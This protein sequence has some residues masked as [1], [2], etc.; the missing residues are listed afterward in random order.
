MYYDT[1]LHAINHRRASS[2]TG[3]T[4]IKSKDVE[5]FVSYQELYDLSLCALGYL[6][7]R[8]LKPKDELVMQIED[9]RSFFVVFWA[10]LLGGIIPV[11]VTIGNNDDHREK[12]FRIWKVLNN[13]YLIISQK[14]WAQ[15]KNYSL[16][17][18][19]SLLH[20]DIENST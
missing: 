3:I 4:F 2:S 13:P 1:L 16:T 12:L 20:T 19:F 6:Q 10:C 8:G 14:D 9:S 5:E 15:H 11:P 18:D 17:S 7:Q